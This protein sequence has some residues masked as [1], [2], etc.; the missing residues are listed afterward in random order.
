MKRNISLERKILEFL[1]GWLRPIR[2]GDLKTELAK[3][4]IDI[5]HSSL[6]SVI[7][8]LE[9]EGLL[10]WEKYG[11]VALTEKGKKEAAHNQRHFHL[12]AM[13]L[14]QTLD[15]SIEQAKKESYQ[16]SGALSC[17]LIDSINDALNNPEICVCSDSIPQIAECST[18]R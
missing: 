11:P 16:I 4:G 18:P 15:I 17:D 6:N 13:F 2:V 9:K 1:H 8:R 12:F 14:V 5:P 10:T 3:E 7:Q